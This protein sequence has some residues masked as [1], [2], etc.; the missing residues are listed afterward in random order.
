MIEVGEECTTKRND[1]TRR[2]GGVAMVYDNGVSAFGVVG[3]G[4][5]VN[6]VE[7]A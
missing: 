4:E 2:A 6:L 3:D 5:T 1:F 7:Q